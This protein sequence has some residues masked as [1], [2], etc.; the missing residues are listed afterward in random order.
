[1]IKLK[2]LLKE[3]WSAVELDEKSKAILT[4]ALGDKI[5]QGWEV[6][7][8]HMTINFKEPVS[9]ELVGQKVILTATSLGLSDKA[10]AV[11]VTSG[12]V[13]SVNAIP[14]VTVAIDRTNGG[15]PKDSNAIT[16]WQKIQ[17]IQLTGTVKNYD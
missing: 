9:S 3:G 12:G 16:D 2:T 15:K 8:H 7:A 13:Q 10:L 17:P 1:M 4:Q 6:I 11:K 5:P 14:H